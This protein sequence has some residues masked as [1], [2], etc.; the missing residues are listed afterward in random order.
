MQAGIGLYLLKAPRATVAFTNGQLDAVLEALARQDLWRLQ[1]LLW[2]RLLPSIGGTWDSL[3]DFLSVVGDCEVQAQAAASAA[4]AIATLTPQP[5]NS[6]RPGAGTTPSPAAQAAS[7]SS[8][9]GRPAGG[10][11]TSVRGKGSDWSVAVYASPAAGPSDW[12]TQ[13]QWPPKAAPA[14]PAPTPVPD[15]RTAPATA[16]SA[17]VLY[18]K[19]AELEEYGSLLSECIRAALESAATRGLLAAPSPAAAAR[20]LLDSAAAFDSRQRAPSAPQ[21]LRYTFIPSADWLSQVA[22]AGVHVG[23]RLSAAQVSQLLHD[24]DALAP[25]PVE[26]HGA[27]YRWL[28]AGGQAAVERCV[29]WHVSRELWTP[30]ETVTVLQALTGKCS[31]PPG[32]N[33]CALAEGLLLACPEARANAGLLCAFLQDAV[34]LAAGS[35]AGRSVDDEAIS[36]LAPEPRPLSPAHTSLVRVALN[37][38]ICLLGALPADSAGAR[39]AAAAGKARAASGAA[40]S[41][42]GASTAVDVSW[43]SRAFMFETY[44]R[45]LQAARRFNYPLEAFRMQEYAAELYNHLATAPGHELVAVGPEGLTRVL[46]AVATTSCC[47]DPAWAAAFE[48]ACLTL[49]AVQFSVGYT[50]PKR[51]L[52]LLEAIAASLPF[53]MP[54]LVAASKALM[55]RLCD[56][57]RHAGYFWELLPLMGTLERRAAAASG[58]GWQ[59]HSGPSASAAQAESLWTPV[60]GASASGTGAGTVHNTGPSPGARGWRQPQPAMGG[61]AS[62]RRPSPGVGRAGPAKGSAAAA[63]SG[64]GLLPLVPPP[65]MKRHLVSEE[66]YAEWSEELGQKLALSMAAWSDQ[67]RTANLSV[68]GIGREG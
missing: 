66:E 34:D 52:G 18:D 24:L 63:G 15:A 10:L 16:A 14:A 2:G 56:T 27:C 38:A 41:T 50:H 5:G 45:L 6:A 55:V 51:W 19:Q 17:S 32:E 9:A 20:Q 67:D 22:V 29:L 59:P 49:V 4:A 54:G 44:P 40:A 43:S 42:S 26:Y 31:Q 60:S 39:T 1:S 48:R 12:R 61:A 21:S 58:A 65:D 35:T 30:H 68:L 46:A 28:D 3:Q 11:V 37:R 33:V 13:P 36:R 23:E 62:M 7:A 47:S 57:R 25:K 64:S 8:L 53:P